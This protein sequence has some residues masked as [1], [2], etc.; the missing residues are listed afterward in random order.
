MIRSNTHRPKGVHIA[1][2]AST[3]KS[4]KL[5][6]VEHDI[7]MQEAFEQFAKSIANGDQWAVRF[8]EKLN[9]MRVK[10]ELASVGLSRKF[11]MRTRLTHPSELD[12]EALYSLI[13]EGEYSPVS[14]KGAHDEDV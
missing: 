10:N 8:L 4:F 5:R 13:D 7:S 9:I 6:L 14:R 1:L 11:N 2:Q 12:T 3:H